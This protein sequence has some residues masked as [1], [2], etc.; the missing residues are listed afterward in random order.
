MA[1][2]NKYRITKEII[3]KMNRKVSRDMGLEDDT[4]WVATNKVHKSKKAY[5]RKDKRNKKF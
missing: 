3:H 2:K 5:K 4:G 1:K